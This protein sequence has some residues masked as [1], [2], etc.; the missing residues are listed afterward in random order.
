MD[1]AFI[2]LRFSFIGTDEPIGDIKKTCI[3]DAIMQEIVAT[4]N[5]RMGPVPSFDIIES[6]RKVVSFHVDRGTPIPFVCP[7]GSEKP[8]GSGIDIAEVLA[9]RTIACLDA[10]I[11]IHYPAGIVCNVR[12]EDV[13]APHLFNERADEARVEARAYCAQFE[14][15]IRILGYGFIHAWRESRVV[16]ENQFNQ[17][18]D[19]ILP[20][21]TDH[22]MEP[23]NMSHFHMLEGFGWKSPMTRERINEGLA[24]YRMLYPDMTDADRLRKF[25]RYLADALAR[26]KLNL[27]GVNPEWQ[28]QFID[29]SFV[30]PARSNGHSFGRRCYYRT[31]QK[32]ISSNHIP[33]WRAKG[34]IVDAGDSVRP[35]L[36]SFRELPS[37]LIPGQIGLSNGAESLNVRCDYAPTL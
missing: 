21:M 9:M 10:R 1:T 18:A 26:K 15:M 36:M 27:R 30:E 29:L 7:W 5:L 16:T 14:T 23:D 19:F 37:N 8:D 13:S 12:M 34:V 22:V 35:R 20:T 4:K 24:H 25:A 33:P 32:N 28:E 2:I 11:R 31:V 3:V 6:I 17:M